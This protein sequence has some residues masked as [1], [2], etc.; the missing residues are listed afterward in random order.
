M[1]AYTRIPIFDSHNDN[2]AQPR[3][4]R[5][6]AARSFFERSSHG[7]IEL[8]RARAGSVECLGLSRVGFGSDMDGASPPRAIGDAAGFPRR[9]AALRET[10]FDEP[11]RAQLAYSNWLRMLG[12]RWANRAV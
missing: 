6:G 1:S 9:I 7:H 11:A 8:P 5:L 10:G 4:A 12:T 2:A 3:S